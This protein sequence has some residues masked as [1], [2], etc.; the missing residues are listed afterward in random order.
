MTQSTSRRSL[1]AAALALTACTAAAQKIAFRQ[2]T[3]DLG[4]TL[5]H[6]S[7]TATYTFRNRDTT[8]LVIQDV[9][10]G[11]GCLAPTWTTTPVPKGGEGTIS[12]TYDARQLGT[13]DRI[14]LVRTNASDTPVRLRMKGVVGT[15]TRRTLSDLYPQRI[16]DIALS[17]TYVEFADVARGDSAT[18]R[19]D[20]LNDSKEVYT[21]QLMHLPPYITARF[22]PEMVARGRRGRIDLTLHSDRLTDT[23]LSQTTVYLARHAGDKIGHDNELTLASVLLPDTTAMHAALLKPDFRIS[24]TTLPL[25]RLGKKKKLTGR[26]TLTNAGKGV[27]RLTSIQAFDQ[28]LEVSLP[29]RELAPGESITMQITL[30]ARYLGTV[31]STPRV[32]LITNDPRHLKET[33]TVTFE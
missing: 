32:L 30:L 1:L 33:V 2:T 29:K 25:G 9:D 19:I 28:A 21:P 10:A 12:V 13:F 11:C 18:A 15:S 20:L 3:A 7:V 8:P 22:V 6:K 23:G 4:T 5:W 31:R 17:T 14:I 16:G 26:I 27:L 24:A